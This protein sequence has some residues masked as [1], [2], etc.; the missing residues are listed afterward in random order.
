MAGLIEGRPI[1]VRRRR[2]GSENKSARAPSKLSLLD[3]ARPVSI[4][5]STLTV[6]I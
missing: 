5:E 6:C 3:G 4:T 2:H 1:D